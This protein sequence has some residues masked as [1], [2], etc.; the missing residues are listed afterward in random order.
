MSNL[1]V[2]N[3]SIAVAHHQQFS[4]DQIDLIKRTVAKD[5][6]DAELSL[7]LHHSQKL[8]LDPLAKQIYFTKRK[9]YKTGVEVVTIL[10]AID[11]YRLIA[12]RTGLYAGNDDPVFEEDDKG[13]LK[14]TVTIYKMVAG[15]RCAFTASARWSQYYP[16]EKMGFMW[17]KMPHLMLGKCAEGLALRKAFPAE[18]SGTYTPEEMDQADKDKKEESAK[19]SIQQPAPSVKP[20]SYDPTNSAH[21]LWLEDGLKKFKLV[22][23][24]NQ[25]DQLQDMCFGKN[26]QEIIEIVKS[27]VKI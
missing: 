4:K 5:A 23:D 24:H 9:N 16:G 6:T 20:F 7:F 27:M 14:A 18:L 19:L 2:S 13:P 25:F 26:T 12:D 3:N 11:G 10:V 17:D 22:L 15:Q 1:A 8:G 21:V